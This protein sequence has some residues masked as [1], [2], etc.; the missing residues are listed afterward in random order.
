MTN[1]QIEERMRD[2]C[3]ELGIDIDFDAGGAMDMWSPKGKVF[4]AT[5]CHVCCAGYGAYTGDTYT[6]ALRSLRRDLNMGLTDCDNPNLNED[7]CEYCK[8][9]D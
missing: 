8:G 1:Y 7:G 4:I 2:Q 6:S 5:S 9:D 3:K